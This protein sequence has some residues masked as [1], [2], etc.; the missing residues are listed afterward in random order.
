M[1]VLGGGVK[2][3]WDLFIG[4]THEE[5][6]RRAFQVPAERTKIVPS[7]LGDDAGMIG[8]A[9]EALQKIQPREG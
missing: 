7:L 9:A 5:I 3:A 2:D 6:M 8:A 4:A 1:V